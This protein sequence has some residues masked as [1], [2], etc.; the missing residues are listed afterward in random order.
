MSKMFPVY[1]KALWESLTATI[2]A[3]AIFTAIST[4]C[5]VPAD[6]TRAMGAVPAGDTPV[7][8]FVAY[9]AAKNRTHLLYT[10]TAS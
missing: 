7:L 8:T 1:D 4:Y 10:W 6:S 9:E 2:T 3:D 5:S